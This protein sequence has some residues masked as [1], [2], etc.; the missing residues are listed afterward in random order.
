MASA[1]ISFTGEGR[2]DAYTAV[3]ARFTHYAGMIAE[4]SVDFGYD[5]QFDWDSSFMSY[6]HVTRELGVQEV[7]WDSRDFWYQRINGSATYEVNHC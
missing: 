7:V 1:Y 4:N 5:G 6:S 3:E 2:V